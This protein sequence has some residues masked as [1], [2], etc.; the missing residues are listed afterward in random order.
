MKIPNK[1]NPLGINDNN[2]PVKGLDFYCPFQEDLSDVINNIT[3]STNS[4][5]FEIDTDVQSTIGKYCKGTLQS[6]SNTNCIYYSNTASMF[7]YGT[8]DFSFS[9]WL[10]AP[11]WNSYTADNVYLSKKTSNSTSGFLIFRR[12]GGD[13]SNK[14]TM[15]V[16][17]TNALY[18]GSA[19]DAKKWIYWTFVRK[20]GV[21]YWYKNGVL[22][23]YGTCNGNANSTQILRIGWNNQYTSYGVYNTKAL[24]IYN[25]ALEQD[26]IKALY[27]QLDVKY[28]IV[29]DN[30]SCE[31][32]LTSS[33]YTISYSVLGSGRTNDVFC[34]L[35]SGILPTGITLSSDGV[36]SG[37]VNVEEDTVYPITVKLYG[38]DYV[39]KYI[40]INITAKAETILTVV[41]PQ[42]FNFTTE[43]Y[44]NTAVSC[45]TDGLV[46][47]VTLSDNLPSGV[48]LNVPSSPAGYVSI[49]STGTQ[50]SAS[51]KTITA[52][53]T[54]ATHI[55]PVTATFNI[56]VILNQ[57][58]LP[59]QT[60]R[61]FTQDGTQAVETMYKSEKTITPIFTLSGNL[62]NGVS[63]DST[64]GTFSYDG[65]NTTASSTPLSL[66][67]S[68]STGASNPATAN[69]V[70]EIVQGS[71]QSGLVFNAPLIKNYNADGGTNTKANSVSFGVRDNAFGATI[72][73]DSFVY[74]MGLEYTATNF[75]TAGNP[76]TI[77]CWYNFT[78]A[79]FQ[80]NDANDIYNM[81][82]YYIGVKEKNKHIGYQ[83]GATIHSG[84]NYSPAIA[85]SPT[86]YIQI[87]NNGFYYIGDGRWHCLSTAFDGT[88][89]YN[90]LDGILVA[91][92]QS[93]TLNI[94]SNDLW[95]GSRQ[96]DR[97]YWH[98]YIRQFAIHNFAFTTND[99]VKYIDNTY[100]GTV[101]KLTYLES[102]G[103]QYIDT[104]ILPDYANGDEVQISLF[105]PSFSGLQ[106]ITFGSRSSTITNGLYITP[107]YLIACD[108]NGYSTQQ[109][110]EQGVITDKNLIMKINASVIDI[111]GDLSTTYSIPRSN[112]TS[113]YPVY[114]FALNNGG[115]SLS[116]CFATNMKLYYFKYYHN[117]TLAQHLVPALNNGV[118]CLYDEVSGTF[119]YNAGT[120]TFN[121][122]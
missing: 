113:D 20:D 95:L 40:N 58:T 86:E 117:G 26:Q 99:A 101:R 75:P 7:Q 109:L 64:N 105:N 103:T 102:T 19:A 89:I 87:L 91:K 69:I 92:Y 82:N 57:I 62:P 63:F 121:Y 45:N 84:T 5:Y 35:Y 25:R 70:V 83:I 67:I 116:E 65:T 21:G 41:S 66:T 94:T 10:Q 50:T 47:T 79:D 60:I 29:A 34:E 39:D 73:A 78:S 15:R 72:T 32:T 16:D 68:S 106:P 33:T 114:L 18:T 98:G 54:T 81:A 107:I 11:N 51:S 112:I 2:L 23:N 77:S 59:P 71:F 1:F 31:F 36:L 104:G 61:F 48:Y 27:K 120:G 56:N 93:S 118:P 24:R 96:N 30:Q 14:L 76:F 115:S 122:A 9:F 53:F 6:K 52:T 111:S 12:G 4:T 42:T 44:T 55:T 8:G 43:S 13:F 38:S 74:N 90:Y 37:S 100:P 22:D 28:Y 46:P 119:K 108:S 17:G 3:G 110:G 88:Y 97:R 80:A 85:W 49:Y